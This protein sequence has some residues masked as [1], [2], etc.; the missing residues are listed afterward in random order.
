MIKQ[1]HLELVGVVTPFAGVGVHDDAC[2]SY[3]ERA[4]VRNTTRASRAAGSPNSRH[5]TTPYQ[6]NAL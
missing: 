3:R 5:T 6:I 1:T 2:A 4:D